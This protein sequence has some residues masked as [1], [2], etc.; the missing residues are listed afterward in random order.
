MASTLEIRTAELYLERLR[1]DSYPTR[2]LPFIS[3]SDEELWEHA[4]EVDEFLSSPR[5]ISE[6]FP[7][8]RESGQR[9]ILCFATVD[10]FWRSVHYLGSPRHWFSEVREPIGLER[11]T[12]P[13]MILPLPIPLELRSFPVVSRVYQGGFLPVGGIIEFIESELERLLKTT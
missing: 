6:A 8:L 13:E 7:F 1:R 4:H 2:Q 3:L 11:V 10:E 5:W 12:N 9:I